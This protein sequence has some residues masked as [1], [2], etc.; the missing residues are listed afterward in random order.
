[1]RRVHIVGRKNA[2]KTALIVELIHELTRRGWSV[3]TIKHTPHHHSIDTRGKDSFRHREA[4]ASPAA[5]IT[6]NATAVFLPR[7]RGEEAYREL[8]QFYQQCDLVLVEGNLETSATKVEVWRRGASGEPLACSRNDVAA[9]ITD[10]EVDLQT[11]LWPRADVKALVD[12][13]QKLM[14]MESP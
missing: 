11:P 8:A 6:G 7:L 10:D 13:L 3:G 14:A 5:L 12:R 9:V 4:G 2:G 1:M